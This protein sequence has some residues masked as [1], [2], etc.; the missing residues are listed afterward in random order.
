[1]A[2]TLTVNVEPRKIGKHHSKSARNIKK[3]PA[4]VYGPNLKNQNVLLDELF[5][6]RHS[7]SNFESAI[8]QTESQ[9]QEINSLKVMLKNIQVHPKTGR[10]IHV[11]LYALDM[12][13]TIRVNVSVEFQGTPKGVK[14]EG[15][16]TQIVL[17]E[18]EI[19]CNPIDIP[20]YIQVDISDLSVG[21]SIHVSDVSFPAG[22][23]PMTLPER[24]LVTVSLPKEETETDEAAAPAA[25]VAAAGDAAKKD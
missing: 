4:V 13:A 3:I 6:L 15:G 14:E 12:S 10:P 5:V 19:E 1:M 16:L 25:D 23:K 24:T 9:N 20:K 8:F 21:E 18:I 2:T 11:D 7:N 17:R 22:I